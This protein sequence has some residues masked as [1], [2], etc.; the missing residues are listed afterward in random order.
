MGD[1][2]LKRT[3]YKIRHRK[4]HI[5]YPHGLDVLGAELAYS[6][7]IFDTGGVFPGN[8]MFEVEAHDMGFKTGLKDIV[9]YDDFTKV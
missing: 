4:V 8:N 1:P 9:K 6:G 3:G 5:C 7:V 2:F